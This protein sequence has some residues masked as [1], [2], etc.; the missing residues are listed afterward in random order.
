MKR[1]A[2]RREFLIVRGKEASSREG[3]VWSVR[4][5]H[6]WLELQ[7]LQPESDRRAGTVMA[8]GVGHSERP[9]GQGTVTTMGDEARRQLWGVEHSDGR[10]GGRGTVMAPRGRL[11]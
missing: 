10:G 8:M 11:Q 2:D 1:R 4:R 6:T 7:E 3:W 9:R 5:V